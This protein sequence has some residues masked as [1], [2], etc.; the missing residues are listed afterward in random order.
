[1]LF[2]IIALNIYHPGKVLQGVKSD[3]SEENKARQAEKKAKKQA[4]KDSKKEG[5]LY[6]KV[7]NGSGHN[8]SD[9]LV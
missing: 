8:S 3:F 4:K 9:E 1:M 7:G 2:A 6:A 5:K